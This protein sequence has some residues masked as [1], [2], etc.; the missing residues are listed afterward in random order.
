MDHVYTHFV[1]NY[2]SEDILNQRELVEEIESITNL[3]IL[4]IP[5]IDKERNESCIYFDFHPVIV[6]KHLSTNI[7]TVSISGDAIEGNLEFR[8]LLSLA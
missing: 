4:S 7:M 6:E 2:L 3:T 8:S 1:K 5:T